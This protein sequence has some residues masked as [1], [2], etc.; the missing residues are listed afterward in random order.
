MKT[1]DI[2]NEIKFIANQFQIGQVVDLNK[3]LNGRINESYLVT[4]SNNS[5]FVL[6]KLHKVFNL[7]L[8][9]DIK[10]VTDYLN[11]RGLL[12]PQLVFTKKNEL[13]IKVG[14]DIW[15]MMTY[16]PGAT[17]DNGI[18]KELAECAG[19]LVGQ[20]HNALSDFDYQ[21]HHKIADFHNTEAILANLKKVEENF[22]NSK[23]HKILGKLTKQVVSE[24]EKIE[25]SIEK[26][27]D[28]IIHGD[29]KLNN[30]RFDESKKIAL[31]LIDLDT[32]G[33]NKIVID[34]GDAVRSWCRGKDGLFNPSIFEAMIKGYFYTADFITK[35]EKEA[36]LLGVEVVTLELCARYI[37]DAYEEG[38]FKLDISTYSSLFQQNMF[39]AINLINF[40]YDLQKQ[41][42]FVKEVIDQYI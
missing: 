35:D 13:G 41:S 19:K 32:L 15:R 7:K 20:F 22:K 42:K 2:S 40:Y 5:K 21:F 3:I 30:I 8:L 36:I 31:C 27:P 37:I 9:D 6:Q 29:L 24:Y 12:T 25:G 33:E 23:K 1:I 34:I 26:L 4:D 14:E 38:Y 10:A 17:I 28:R 11:Q 16:I 39:Q 18:V